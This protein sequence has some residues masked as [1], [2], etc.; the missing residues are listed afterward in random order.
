M[1]VVVMLMVLLGFAGA[2]LRWGFN[3]TDGV[4]NP[5]RERR[6]QWKAW[7]YLARRQEITVRRKRHHS[8]P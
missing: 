7:H 8:V 3:S 1:E 6:R 2:A 4:D 5:E